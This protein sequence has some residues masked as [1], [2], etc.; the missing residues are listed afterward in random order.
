MNSL[1]M[2]KLILVLRHFNWRFFINTQLHTYVLQLT[3]IMI[4]LQRIT[5]IHTYTQLR[6]QLVLLWYPLAMYIRCSYVHLTM[7]RSACNFLAEVN[8]QNTKQLSISKKVLHFMQTL[9]RLKCLCRR[10]YIRKMMQKKP[11][12]LNIYCIILSPPTQEFMFRGHQFE[13]P[14]TIAQTPSNTVQLNSNLTPACVR[15]A[16]TRFY[17]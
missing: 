1:N 17:F 3:S 16:E 2:I 8:K 6:M 15:L 14:F 7:L 4:K 13:I 9:L 12:C 10:C 5:N 11:L